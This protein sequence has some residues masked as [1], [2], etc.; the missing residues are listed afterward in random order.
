VK[1]GAI[2]ILLMAVLLGLLVLRVALLETYLA[3]DPAR[4][5][6]IWPSHPAAIMASGLARMGKDAAGGHS[7][8]RS[9]VGQIIDASTKAPLAAEP[10]LVRGVDATLQGK[11]DLAQL[12][13]AAARDRDPRSIPAR[14]FLADHF[15]KSG[16]ARQGL[17]EVSALTRLVPGSMASVG[18]YL[19]AFARDPRGRDEVRQLL[20]RNPE[21]EPV[22]L[23]ELA[24]DPGNARL[25]VSL[26]S[27]RTGEAI[28]PWQQKLL[29]SMIAAGQF[30]D[31]NDVWTRFSGK[32]AASENRQDGFKGAGRG[33]FSWTLASGPSGVVESGADGS[34][35]VIYYGR[36]DQ[37][38]ATRLFVLGPADH[39]IAMRITGV[40]G[41]AGSMSWTVRCLPSGAELGRLPLG[42]AEQ[43]IQL[44]FKVPDHQ[45]EAQRVE[46]VGNAPELPER[47]ALAITAFRIESEKVR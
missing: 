16:R 32:A 35:H 29:E 15:L 14:Y 4:A 10:F 24:S 47:A 6:E 7:V 31:A 20:R 28:Q 8:S 46:L 23:Q 42:G 13:F 9:L 40:S 2:A 21:L 37:V 26:W 30:Q 17:V 22:V 44:L 36:D 45:C 11:R 43:D 5:A 3:R 1:P 19:A 38:L 12:S 33:P 25:I 39:Q 34:A 18:P 41:D 27:G